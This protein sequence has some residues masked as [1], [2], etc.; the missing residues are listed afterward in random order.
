[1]DRLTTGASVGAGAS[2]ASVGA[3]TS[4]ASEPEHDPLFPL[5]VQVQPKFLQSPG[6]VN[7][8]QSSGVG[9]ACLERIV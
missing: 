8:A 3:G 6:L 2:G 9:G 5:P 1:M 7:T 4:G